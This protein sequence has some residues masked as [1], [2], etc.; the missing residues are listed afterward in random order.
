MS[1]L[2]S[3]L[4]IA[5]DWPQDA[6]WFATWLSHISSYQRLGGLLASEINSGRMDIAD[7]LIAC[8]YGYHPISGITSD[9][10]RAP[11]ARG[12]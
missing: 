8:A 2:W 12:R 1:E 10:L 6:A 5:H 11:P 9:A 4:R 7:T 3:L